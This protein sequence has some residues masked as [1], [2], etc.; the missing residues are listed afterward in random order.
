[1]NKGFTL[2]EIS[3]VL[4]IIGL[5]SGI[6]L[7]GKSLIDSSVILS[8]INQISRYNSAVT[9]FKLK[10]GYLPG[11]IPDPAATSIGLTPRGVTA[12]NGD[13]N[14][15]IGGVNVVIQAGETLTFWNDLSTT[16]LIQEQ[17]IGTVY[18]NKAI[19]TTPSATSSTYPLD[20]YIPRAAIDNNFISIFSRNGQ[21]FFAITRFNCAGCGIATDGGAFGDMGLTVAQ[22]YTLDNKMDDGMP[23]SGRVTAEK[24]GVWWA[25]SFSSWYGGQGLGGSNMTAWGASA[26]S[27]F[28]NGNVAGVIHHYSMSAN[29][30]GNVNCSLAIKF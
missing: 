26:T 2:I 5:I 23:Q 30:R 12:G 10:Y 20:K 27:C 21:S 17:L 29:S 18:L 28:D 22:A 19:L 24:L 11:D 9:T 13:G 6:T 1:M 25:G 15:M 7:V 14:D 4:V 16:K 3:I 8:Q